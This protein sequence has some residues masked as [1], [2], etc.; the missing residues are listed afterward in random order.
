MCHGIVHTT[1]GFKV[2]I[3]SNRYHIVANGMPGTIRDDGVGRRFFVRRK[4]Q[5]LCIKDES[6]HIIQ[7]FLVHGFDTLGGIFCLCDNDRIPSFQHK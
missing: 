4:L 7:H 3:G 2:F 6:R 5:C 1:S